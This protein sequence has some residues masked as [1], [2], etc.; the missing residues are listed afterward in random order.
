MNAAH[1]SFPYRASHHLLYKNPDK[2]PQIIFVSMQY[3][4]ERSS[5]SNISNANP[6][7]PRHLA[8]RLGLAMG[9]LWLWSPRCVSFLPRPARHG[10]ASL[11]DGLLHTCPETLSAATIGTIVVTGI[12]CWCCCICTPQHVRQSQRCACGRRWCT[13]SV[14]TRLPRTVPQAEWEGLGQH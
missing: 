13:S 5:R 11:S 4:S 10:G 14:T 3:N 7:T 2:N 1:S 6:H 8:V 12:I 9:E